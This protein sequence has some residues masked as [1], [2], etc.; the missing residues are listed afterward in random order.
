MASCLATV[1]KITMTRKVNRLLKKLRFI[2]AE[3]YRFGFRISAAASF[4]Q[5]TTPVLSQEKIVGREEDINH[6]I[7]LLLSKSST[8]QG[9]IILA[10]V[11]MGGIGKTTLAQMIFNH[12]QFRDY[13]RAWVYVSEELDL[14]KIARSIISQ[15][16]GNESMV[17]TDAIQLIMSTSQHQGISRRNMLLVLDDMWIIDPEKSENLKSL[18][19]SI[20][21]KDLEVIVIITTRVVSVARQICTLQ[22]YMLC[23]LPDYMCWEIIQHASGFE[24]R[25]DKEHLEHIGMMIARKCG[26]VPLAAKLFGRMLQFKDANGWSTLMNSDAWNIENDEG[27]SML[28]TLKLSFLSMPLHL[29]SCFAYLSMFPNNRCIVKHDLIHQWIAAGLVEQPSPT[30]STTDLAELYIKH[31][32]DL[33]FLHNSTSASVSF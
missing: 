1:S 7:D 4:S 26:G 3:S 31:L 17:S 14:R 13:S 19:S 33:S 28:S 10:I 11:G 9:P 8:R 23:A 22:P 5:E 27:S 6:I 32:L 12:S 25:P 16:T 20:G 24:Y 30:L 18:V 15:V 2:L 21:N 29:R